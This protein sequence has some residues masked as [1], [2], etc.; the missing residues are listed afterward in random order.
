[1][2]KLILK[3]YLWVKILK[4]H[5]KR[6]QLFEQL[7]K[8]LDSDFNAISTVLKAEPH[9]KIYK[10]EINFIEFFIGTYKF[11]LAA[12]MLLQGTDSQIIYK[13]RLI[14]FDP[15]NSTRQIILDDLDIVTNFHK[16]S[17]FIKPI[18]VAV[19]TG[20]S[21]TKVPSKLILDIGTDYINQIEDA[22]ISRLSE[23]MKNL[24]RR[25]S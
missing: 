11:R 15:D 10:R 8:N 18:E 19:E 25:T 7:T 16:E 9:R 2:K 4:T 23:E 17:E 12:R 5:M 1:M 6:I 20:K 21:F 3:F 24:L 22:I 14:E 13:T